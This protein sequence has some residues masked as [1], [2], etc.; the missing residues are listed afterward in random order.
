ML[1]NWKNSTGFRAEPAIAE[2][3]GESVDEIIDRAELRTDPHGLMQRL[4]NAWMESFSIIAQ[5]NVWN[6]DV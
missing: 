3:A 5:E 4:L 1:G 6:Q 2:D